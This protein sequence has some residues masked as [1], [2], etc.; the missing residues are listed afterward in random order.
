MNLPFKVVFDEAADNCVGLSASTTEPTVEL[1]GW[2]ASWFWR[3]T[4][5]VQDALILGQW[6]CKLFAILQWFCMPWHS[7]LTV[8]SMRLLHLHKLR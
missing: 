1:L 6:L 5:I 3:S 8:C 4:K 2:H 7:K